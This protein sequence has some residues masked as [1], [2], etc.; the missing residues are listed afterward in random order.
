MNHNDQII[1]KQNHISNV[2]KGWVKIEPNPVRAGI[3]HALASFLIKISNGMH[4]LR[5]PGASW[6]EKHALCISLLYLFHS[7]CLAEIIEKHDPDSEETKGMIEE[8]EKRE[9]RK[10]RAYLQSVQLYETDIEKLSSNEKHILFEHYYEGKAPDLKFV[11][12]MRR[13]YDLPIREISDT[14]VDQQ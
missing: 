13:K 2:P 7:E 6:V 14:W 12:K 3:Y 9:R 5:I 4:H 1:T 8:Y 11:N 10:Y